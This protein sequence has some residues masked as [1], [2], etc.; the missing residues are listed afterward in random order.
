[1]KYDGLMSIITSVEKEKVFENIY[2]EVIKLNHRF[3]RQHVMSK[4]IASGARGHGFKFQLCF[5]LALQP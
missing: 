4:Y 5:G 1:M 3:E 2:D